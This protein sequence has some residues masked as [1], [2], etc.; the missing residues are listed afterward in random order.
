[1]LHY[2]LC[3]LYKIIRKELFI[4]ASYNQEIDN[5]GGGLGWGFGGGGIGF[6]IIILLFFACFSGG[7]LFGRHD[8]HHDGHYDGYE[9]FHGKFSPCCGTSN[10]QVDKD[11]LT[12]RDAGIIEQNKIYERQLEQ[13][14][15][16]Q[17]MVIQEQKQQLFV[18]G[19]FG[20]LEK[21]LACKFNQIEAQLAKK[22]NVVPVYANTVD[23]CTQPQLNCFDRFR[24]RGFDRGRDDCCWC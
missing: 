8:G 12:S 18:G 23:S 22:P 1:M 19:M 9:Y 4:I 13:K 7:G 24:E 6:L 20:N 3:I 10:C 15:N 21:E 11:V 2:A 16:E 14:I 17:N 5:I